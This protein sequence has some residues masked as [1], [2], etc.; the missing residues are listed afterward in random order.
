[1][2]VLSSYRKRRR[3]EKEAM[4]DGHRDHRL[5][6]ARVGALP[7]GWCNPSYRAF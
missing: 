2:D 3:R 6:F 4:G 5:L 1:M 7:T